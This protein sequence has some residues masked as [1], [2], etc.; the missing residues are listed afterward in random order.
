MA[1][2]KESHTISERCEARC[3]DWNDGQRACRLDRCQAFEVC[4]SEDP[5]LHLDEQAWPED[6]DRKPAKARSEDVLFWLAL[7]R[8]EISPRK[9]GKPAPVVIVSH[10][11]TLNRVD[12]MIPFAGELARR[13]NAVIAIDCV[14]H[15]PKPWN[16]VFWMLPRAFGELWPPPLIDILG[17]TRV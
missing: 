7:P 13:G 16:R 1:S 9:D 6:L 12:T 10:G 14:S 3:A 5:W 15:G 4:E 8:K 17:D 2:E 11:Y